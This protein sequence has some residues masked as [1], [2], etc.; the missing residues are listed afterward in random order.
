MHACMQIYMYSVYVHIC[1]KE[2]VLAYIGKI[3]NTTSMCAR[4]CMCERVCMWAAKGWPSTIG[5]RRKLW[6][7]VLERENAKK[8][9][10][11][12]EGKLVFGFGG[13]RKR[14]LIWD[15]CRRWRSRWGRPL[16]L[17]A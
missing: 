1:N 16:G 10:K 5:G 4:V 17:A 13:E 6:G 7:G 12:K 8:R 14:V 3:P 11:P 2:S 15:W 9:E